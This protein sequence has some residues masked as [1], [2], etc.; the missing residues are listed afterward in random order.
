MFSILQN[1]TS[2]YDAKKKTEQNQNQIEGQEKK[3]IENISHYYAT[4]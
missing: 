4:V 1:S 3:R 2:T